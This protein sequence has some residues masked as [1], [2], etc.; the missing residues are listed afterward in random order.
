[1]TILK[2]KQVVPVVM[3]F[4]LSACAGNGNE[5]P[6]SKLPVLLVYSSAHC[7]V[8][9]REPVLSVITSQQQLSN[10]VAKAGMMAGQ[11][12]PVGDIS[13]NKDMLLLVNMGQKPTGGYGFKLVDGKSSYQQAWAHVQLEWKSPAKGMMLTQALTSPC[14]MLSIPRQAYAGIRVFDQSGAARLE[15]L[16]K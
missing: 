3:L 7:G 8:T 1:M 16:L 13:F 11:P 9:S 4:L 5:Q 2:N 12:L 10:N 14:V 15:T 6:S